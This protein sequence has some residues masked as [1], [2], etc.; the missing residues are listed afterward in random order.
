MKM[1]RVYD[2]KTKQISTIPEA[3][4]G[5]GMIRAN[6]EKGEEFW[7][8]AQDVK[9]SRKPIH[10]PFDAERRDLIRTQI[11]QPLWE[12]FRQSLHQWEEGFRVDA[13]PDKEIDLW[14][15]IAKRYTQF[16]EG[17]GFN[18]PQKHDVYQAM[19]HCTMA[20]SAETVLGTIEL[21]ALTR[22]EAQAA[23]DAFIAPDPDP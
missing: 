2:L 13:H 10:P 20:T 11:Q 23:I 5:P 1:V 18:L 14:R 9:R 6:N 12:V 15:R 3:E 7:I 22:E 4:L 8:K 19:L 21:K 17:K 16:I